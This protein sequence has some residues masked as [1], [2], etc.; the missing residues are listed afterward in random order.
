MK[1][2]SKQK[3]MCFCL[4]LIGSQDWLADSV[5][6]CVS[7]LLCFQVFQGNHNAVDEVHAF[8][9]KQSLARYVRIRPMSWEKGICMRFEI[10]GCRTS[11]DA[12]L[13]FWLALA[14]ALACSIMDWSPC[15]VLVDI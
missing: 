4:N 11:G 3:V 2:G 13:F 5:C 9:P 10:Y 12:Q 14:L 6:V 1:D 8:L 15:E 7:R